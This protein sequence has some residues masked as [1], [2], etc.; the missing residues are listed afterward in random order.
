MFFI[1]DIFVTKR[2]NNLISKAAQTNA[3]VSSLFPDNFRD[4]LICQNEEAKSAKKGNL[5][6]FLNDGQTSGEPG[7]KNYL[8]SKPL[9]DLF[10]ETTVMF[11]DVAGRFL[12]L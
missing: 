2:N 1:Y 9:A 8:S 6:T 5:K 7:G 11:A 12:S 10:L 3:I 4:K